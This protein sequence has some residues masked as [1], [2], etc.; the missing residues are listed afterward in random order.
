[1]SSTLWDRGIF[2]SVYAGPLREGARPRKRVQITRREMTGSVPD[3]N[4]ILTLD[5]EQWRDLCNAVH[6][7]GPDCEGKE[8]DDGDGS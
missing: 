8:T 1:M 3:L 7:L 6:H 4:S 5:L 2:I